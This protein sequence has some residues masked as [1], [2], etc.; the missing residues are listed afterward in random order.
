MLRAKVADQ[1]QGAAFL[2]PQCMG[3]HARWVK[4]M[5][6]LRRKNGGVKVN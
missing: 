1:E 4:S 6:E 5:Q 2:E 3:R